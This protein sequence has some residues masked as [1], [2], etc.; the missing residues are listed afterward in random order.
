MEHRILYELS[1]LMKLPVKA[2][3]IILILQTD[4]TDMKES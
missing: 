2:A 1:T 3:G 4:T